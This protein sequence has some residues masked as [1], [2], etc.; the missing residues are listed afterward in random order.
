MNRSSLSFLKTTIIGG[1]LVVIP[2][3]LIIIIFGD[4]FATLMDVTRPMA[5]Y[6]PFAALISTLIVTLLALV[7]ILLICFFTGLIV[8]TSW[9]IAGKHW[10]ENRV[11]NRI[12]MYNIIKNLA[13]QFVGEEGTQFLPAEI[14]LHDSNCAVLGAIVEEL[15]D[16][17]LAV[18]VPS[19]PAAAVGQIYLIPEKRV[20]RLNASL[21]A[22]INSITEWGIGTRK[23][24]E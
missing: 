18:Y 11:L 14:D 20:K 21:G 8:R 17:R 15:G 3:S 22:T 1:L 10:F 9:G 23:L 16:G 2:L 4:L 5:K 12:P 13:H 7:G 6:L 19:T 24:Y